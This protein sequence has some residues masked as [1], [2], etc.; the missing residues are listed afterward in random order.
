MAKRLSAVRSTRHGIMV[1]RPADGT[2]TGAAMALPAYSADALSVRAS[3]L[4]QESG[5]AAHTV[6]LSTR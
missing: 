1:I 4:R 5:L 2:R 3:V 6:A